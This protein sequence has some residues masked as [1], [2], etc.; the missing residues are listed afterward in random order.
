MTTEMQM[1]ERRDPEEELAEKLEMLSQ[2]ALVRKQALR[3]RV[4]PAVLNHA[5]KLYVALPGVSWMFDVPSASH[6]IDAKESMDL[7]FRAM[8]EIGGPERMKEY[9]EQVLATIEA[10]KRRG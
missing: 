3:V 6:V 7:F 4:Q 9:M 1:V 5:T 2:A 8:A 10:D